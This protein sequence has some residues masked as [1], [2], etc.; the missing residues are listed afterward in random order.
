MEQQPQ[1]QEQPTENPGGKVRR[2]SQKQYQYPMLIGGLIIIIGVIFWMAGIFKE[3]TADQASAQETVTEN[4]T[5]ALAV[6]GAQNAP[7]MLSL[8][9]I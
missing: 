7:L 6:P 4:Q 8:I 9:H 1:P 5:E 2:M 3:D